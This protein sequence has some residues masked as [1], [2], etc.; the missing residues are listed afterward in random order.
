MNCQLTR[1]FLCLCSSNGLEQEMLLCHDTKG[2]ISR[3]W[4]S[5][6]NCLSHHRVR[7]GK[8]AGK[9]MKLWPKF[10]FS[11]NVLQEY[12]E[13]SMKS[14]PNWGKSIFYMFCELLYFQNWELTSKCM[15]QARPHVLRIHLKQALQLWWK[16]QSFHSD[17][18]ITNG[19]S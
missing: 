14:F 10:C 1:F 15:G 4:L 8:D 19:E 5:P 17:N 7:P 13:T 9:E 12:P 16:F 11:E 6:N 18:S 2:L 3:I